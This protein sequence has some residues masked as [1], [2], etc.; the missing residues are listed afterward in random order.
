[1]RLF[2]VLTNRVGESH[3]RAYVWAEDERRAAALFAL[4][5]PQ[6][7]VERIDE[8]FAADAEEFVTDLSD[9]DFEFVNPRGG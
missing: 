3:V 1:M 2:R 4:R 7:E 9:S 5:H 6:A 8:L